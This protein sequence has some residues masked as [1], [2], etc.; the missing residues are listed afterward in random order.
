MGPSSVLVEAMELIVI[1]SG[2]PWASV[3]VAMSGGRTLGVGLGEGLVGVTL[4]KADKGRMPL[5]YKPGVVGIGRLRW[6]IMNMCVGWE[7]WVT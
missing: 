2:T 6:D 5:G 3:G 7:N 4:G 1:S